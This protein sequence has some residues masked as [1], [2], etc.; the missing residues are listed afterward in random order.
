MDISISNNLNSAPLS[1][2]VFYLSGNGFG[3]KMRNLFCIIGLI[4]VVLFLAGYYF[5]DNGKY[6]YFL[7][8]ALMIAGFIGIRKT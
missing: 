6:A 2:S 3:N 4:G 5:L 1:L 8:L 7:G